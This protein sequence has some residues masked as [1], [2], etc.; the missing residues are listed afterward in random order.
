MS[1]VDECT[2]QNPCRAMSCPFCDP[3]AYLEQHDEASQ[4]LDSP[5]DD[6]YDDDDSAGAH[7]RMVAEELQRM[8]IRRDAAH[9]LRA[10]ERP[11]AEKA[12]WLPLGD[13]LA[14]PPAE[15]TW[16]IDGW[17]PTD[18]RIVMAAQR[19]AGKTTTVGNLIRS[20]IDGDAWLGTADV[21]P[22][23]GTVVL[24]DFEMSQSKLTDWLRDQKIGDPSR[25]IVVPMRGKGG[26]F[27]ILDDRTRAEWAAKLRQA[28]CGYLI[29]DC[30]RPV[31]D[32]LGMD[33]DKQAGRFLTAFDAL[34]N[35]AGVSEA[36]V[37]HHMGHNGER[38]RG[39]S[40]LRDWPDVEWKIVRKDPDD[41][42]SPRFISAYGRDV[43]QR[44]Q[45][46]GFDAGT[47]RLTS[48]GGTRKESGA[49]EHV[50]YVV[51]LLR[52]HPHLNAVPGSW[53]E[54]A[55]AK[56]DDPGAPGRNEV[57]AA[58]KLAA[59]NG[60]LFATPGAKNATLYRL[61]VTAGH[62]VSSPVRQ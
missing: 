3:M 12:E 22:I 51:A 30:L 33:E 62:E 61:T 47:R 45:Q 2:P 43:D 1:H 60:L 23:S 32:A 49:A 53:F 25:L 46:L 50:P 21:N 26:G 17:M 27:D 41:D 40:R 14:M 11:Q 54:N 15:T 56:D 36:A 55:A 58:V 18:A 4:L 35:E 28:N 20:L 24:L 10:E 7:A 29:L 37:I 19:K 16:R 38:S 52:A 48:L 31:M 9:L 13:L 57:R 59:K 44:E 42:A 6:P 34:L 39:D 5:R 8:R